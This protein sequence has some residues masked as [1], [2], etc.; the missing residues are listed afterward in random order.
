MWIIISTAIYLFII[1]ILIILLPPPTPKFHITSGTCN[2][3]EM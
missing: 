3:H 2:V 1:I